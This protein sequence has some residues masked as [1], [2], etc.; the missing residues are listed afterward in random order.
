MKP[1]AAWDGKGHP[2]RKAVEPIL[3]LIRLLGG[4]EIRYWSTELEIAGIFW[5]LHKM[6]KASLMRFSL[7]LLWKWRKPSA[8]ASLMATKLA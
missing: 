5:V 8:G 6:P 4:A 3:F 1:F 7:P 2:P